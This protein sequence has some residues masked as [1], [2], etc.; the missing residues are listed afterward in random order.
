MVRY[1][2]CLHQESHI[3]SSLVVLTF[4]CDRFDSP[5]AIQLVLFPTETCRFETKS[6]NV[7]FV[8]PYEHWYRHGD[9]HFVVR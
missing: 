6:Y 7:D 3:L 9:I 1:R 4:E 2:I 8:I 5:I